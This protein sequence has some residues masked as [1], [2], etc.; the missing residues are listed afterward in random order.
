M[1]KNIYWTLSGKIKTKQNDKLKKF[2]RSVLVKTVQESGCM[3]YEFW[4]GEGQ[5]KLYIYERYADSKACLEHFKNVKADLP[6]FFKYVE[7]DPLVVLGE[8]SEEVRT[9]FNKM[10]VVYTTYIMGFDDRLD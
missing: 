2:L 9:A 4:F 8:V 3:N 6:K 7:L 5:K 1:T 10:D